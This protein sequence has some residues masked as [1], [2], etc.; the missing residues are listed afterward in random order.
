MK[1]SLYSERKQLWSRIEVFL[2]IPLGGKD[3]SEILTP[4]LMTQIP[5]EANQNLS[6]TFSIEPLQKRLSV[7]CCVA[8]EARM[9]QRDHIWWRR[10][11][12]RHHTFGFR[13][14][15]LEWMHQFHF[16]FTEGSSI[17]KYT[18]SL[19]RGIIQKK[20]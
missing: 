7:C 12:P 4:N 13:S 16:N 10:R 14:I 11:R 15:T 2:K 17:I 9:I 3:F 5:S 19:T 18:K 6:L 8:C 1:T 20:I